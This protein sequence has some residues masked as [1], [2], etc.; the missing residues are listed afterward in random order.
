MG[1][2]PEGMRP[3]SINKLS[4]DSEYKGLT[5]KELFT[6][7][8]QNYNIF[9]ESGTHKGESVR[10][11]LDIGYDKIISVE[12]DS[13]MYSDC[14]KLFEKEIQDGS[15]ILFEGDSR[16]LIGEMFKLVD[17]PAVFW[18]DGHVDGDTGDPVW[19]ELE[20]IKNHHIKNHVIIIDDIPLYFSGAMKFI[21]EDAVKKINP[22]YKIVYEDA[23]NEGNGETYKNYD[24][25]AYIPQD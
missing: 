12:I 7:H 20:A 14:C 9:V 8:K 23:L 18:L 11:A 10:T 4:A 1:I 6:K 19:V 16:E 2:L 3:V 24:L 17:G 13:E 5:R 25:V 21:L 22:E 15:V